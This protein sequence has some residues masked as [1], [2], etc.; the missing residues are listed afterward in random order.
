MY[1][2]RLVL[3]EA[4][5]VKEISTIKERDHLAT[6][7][8]GVPGGQDHT[9]ISLHPTEENLAGRGGLLLESKCKIYSKCDSRQ[10][11]S[12]SDKQTWQ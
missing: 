5:V 8:G 2:P 12:I 3:K 9:Q 6:K 7:I 4:V 11:V 1:P 10:L